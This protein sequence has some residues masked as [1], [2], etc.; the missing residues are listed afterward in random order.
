MERQSTYKSKNKEKEKYNDAVM[1]W[2][3][4]SPKESSDLAGLLHAIA[5]AHAVTNAHN[6]IAH[7]VA[8]C[9]LS[10]R[11]IFTGK[12]FTPGAVCEDRSPPIV[13][14]VAPCLQGP[15]S[16]AR[17]PP[18]ELSARSY[19]RKQDACTATISTFLSKTSAL[20]VVCEVFAP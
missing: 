1:F 19:L 18:Q 12:M 5:I 11:F 3:W 13:C 9:N 15:S 16:Q 10:V 7:C 4:R 20:G 6:N 8:P 14:H 2:R 17:C